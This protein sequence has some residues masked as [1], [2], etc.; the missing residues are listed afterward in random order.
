M[1]LVILCAAGVATAAV[2]APATYNVDPDHT[3]VQFDTDHFGGLSVWRGI[4]VKNR[5]TVTLDKAAGTGKV[6]V[7]TDMSSGIIG[8]AK[9]EE[10]L[11][12]NEFFDAAKYPEAHY[13]GTLGNFV[14]GKPTTVTGNLTFHGVT[15]PVNLKIDSFKCIMHP[16]YKKEDC[17]ADATGTFNRADFGVDMG[18][19]WG[20][21]M[22][23]ILRIQ[24]EALAADAGAPVSK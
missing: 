10:E 16:M 17:G 22:N 8:N 19:A 12:S 7:Y 11:K 24:I 14:D 5:G 9:L 13:Q 2:A 3:H 23:V 1:S 21:N 15:K 18:K 6:D 20:F 4:M